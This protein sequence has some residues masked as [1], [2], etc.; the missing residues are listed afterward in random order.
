[1]SIS[2]KLHDLLT[3]FFMGNGTPVQVTPVGGDAY[4]PSVAEVALGIDFDESSALEQTATG[5]TITERSMVNAIWL[6]MVNVTQ[7]VT[8]RIYHEIDG[9]NPRLF[10]ENTWLSTDDPGV[11]IDGFAVYGDISVTLQCSGGGAGNVA[12]HTLVL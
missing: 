8:I 12:M 5:V 6:D 1:M 3:D 7:D 2:Q 4:V 9:T 11:L 10:Q